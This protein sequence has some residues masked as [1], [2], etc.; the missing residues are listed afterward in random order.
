MSTTP[1]QT[2]RRP[3]HKNPV[4]NRS[5]VRGVEILRAFQPGVDL[6]GNGEIAERTRL[7]RPTVSRLT[8]TLVECGLL[9]YERSQRAYRLAAPVLSL[10]HAMRTGSPVLGAVA[11]LMRALAEKMRINVGLA[12]ADRDEMVYLESFRY[13]R[14][15]A[16]R[17]VV[18]GQRVPMELT[19]LG[20][21]HLAVVD[22]AQRSALLAQ[23]RLRHRADWQR[24]RE[25]IDTAKRNVHAKGYCAASWQPEVV[26]IAAPLVLPGRPIYVLNVS[27]RTT[28]GIPATEK[29]LSGLLLTLSKQA[30]TALLSTNE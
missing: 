3:H 8:Q 11:P 14:K 30:K 5:L 10:A 20:R 26:A 7:S 27:V 2:P 21:A 18:A 1:S 9:E 25:E 15:V 22:D 6:L 16:L 24:L 13:N 12:T 29:Q 17:N 19:S 28:A 23:F 4:L